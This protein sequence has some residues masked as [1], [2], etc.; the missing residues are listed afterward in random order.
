MDHQTENKDDHVYKNA[1]KKSI[2]LFL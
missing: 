1:H 2:T